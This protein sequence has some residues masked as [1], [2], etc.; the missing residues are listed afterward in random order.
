MMGH[1][2]KILRVICINQVSCKDWTIIEIQTL[3][4]LRDDLSN[5][6]SRG[7]V[8]PQQVIY[9][10]IPRNLLSVILLGLM[11]AVFRKIDLGTHFQ[12]PNT[13]AKR[14]RS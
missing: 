7:M 2:I 12:D 9:R 11:F 4:G 8:H 10:L 6:G 5:I 1:Q 14:A 13:F 3:L